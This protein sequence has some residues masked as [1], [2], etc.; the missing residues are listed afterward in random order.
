M[1][2]G[3]SV[4]IRKWR[5]A[6]GACVIALLAAPLL[7]F[8]QSPQTQTVTSDRMRTARSLRLGFRTDARPFSY[9]DATA[10]PAGYSVALCERI[11]AA[12]KSELGMSALELEWIPVVANTRFRTLQQ[13]HVDLI[14]GA[15]TETLARREE[16]SF[17]IPIFPGGIGVLVRADAAV[18]LKDV[19]AGRSQI[20]HPIWRAAAVQAIQARAFSIVEGTASERWLADRMSELRIM[21]KV[22][23]VN[24]YDAGVQAV[25][26]R[27]SDA[28]FGERAVLLDAVRRHPSARDLIVIDRRF[29]YEPLA[30]AVP[31]GDEAFRLL[32]DR[33]LSR[34]YDSGEIIAL[35]T[36]SFGALD[37]GTLTFFQWNALR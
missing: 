1:R 25:I 12:A 35:Y 3:Q 28:F 9:R 32:V 30:L 19:L 10:R 11:A 20:S 26:D 2:R 33:A 18:R 27:R 34:L 16:A 13:G 8:G 23:R 15:E 17:S 21:A 22:A 36:N 37:E 4:G 5:V 14:C 6:S 24:G 7:L 31:R 29:T